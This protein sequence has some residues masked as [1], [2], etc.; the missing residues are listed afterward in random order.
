MWSRHEV[1]GYEIHKNLHT[2][3]F[4]FDFHHKG[5][6]LIIQFMKWGLIEYYDT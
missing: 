3:I 6:S 5:C 2:L 1:G 4:L